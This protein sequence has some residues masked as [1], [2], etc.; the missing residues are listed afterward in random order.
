M[1]IKGAPCILCTDVDVS[2]AR[3]KDL[4]FI[5]TGCHSFFLRS[6]EKQWSSHG[7]DLVYLHTYIPIEPC[8]KEHA[9]L[10]DLDPLCVS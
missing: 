10:V 2:V 1:C 7:A 4:F 8:V 6:T 5:T 9:C 3:Q